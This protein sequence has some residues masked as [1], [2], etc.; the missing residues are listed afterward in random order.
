LT[1]PGTALPMN[2]CYRDVSETGSPAHGRNP[3]TEAISWVRCTSECR[4]QLAARRRPTPHPMWGGKALPPRPLIRGPRLPPPAHPAALATLPYSPLPRAGEVGSRSDPGE[5]ARPQRPNPVVAATRPV[6]DCCIAHTLGAPDPRAHSHT[7]DPRV[8]AHFAKTPPRRS[9]REEPAPAGGSLRNFAK[10]TSAATG[11]RPS[12]GRVPSAPSPA[13]GA[14]P[15]GRVVAQ[16]REKHPRPCDRRLLA[17]ASPKSATRPC[18][19]A[20]RPTRTSAGAGAPRA[21]AKEAPRA[22]E[23]PPHSSPAAAAAR[24]AGVSISSGATGP[25]YV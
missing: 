14:C 9:G 21:V 11:A 1:G 6:P 24:D 10:T 23:T 18:G 3:I 4:T 2:D 15:G 16:F 20:P 25:V 8:V 13:G 12:P 19:T 22:G 5:G 7:T 17:T